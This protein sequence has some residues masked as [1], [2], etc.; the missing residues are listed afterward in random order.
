MRVSAA[1]FFSPG[2][3]GLVENAPDVDEVILNCYRLAD[4]YKQDPTLFLQMPLTQLHI[5][6]HFTI[7]LTTI[8]REAR[9]RERDDE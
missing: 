5:H 7:K 2:A 6:L 4:R 3:G 9:Q 1:K 8:Q